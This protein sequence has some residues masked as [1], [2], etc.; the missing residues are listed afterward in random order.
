MT[1]LSVCPHSSAPLHTCNLIRRGVGN[2]YAR[3]LG[4]RPTN[5]GGVHARC[6]TIFNNPENLFRSARHQPRQHF[7]DLRSH[8]HPR[9]TDRSEG[10]QQAGATKDVVGRCHAKVTPVIRCW[11][12]AKKQ[13]IRGSKRLTST[14]PGQRRSGTGRGSIHRPYRTPLSPASMA[15]RRRVTCASSKT[16][17]AA[18][19]RRADHRGLQ[20]AR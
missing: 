4:S 18:S 12:I 2:T 14:L 3:D 11:R 1:N 7:L 9:R 5:A 8:G 20:A 16:M 15:L 13:D 10:N 6:G 17:C 19:T